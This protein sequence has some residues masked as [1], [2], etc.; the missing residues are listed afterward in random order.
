MTTTS[1]GPADPSLT[2]AVDPASGAT[3]P[4]I[5]TGYE[6]G[7]GDQFRAYVARVR[8]GEMGMLPAIGGLIVLTALFAFLYL[9][10]V[11]PVV[12]LVTH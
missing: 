8:G 3:P 10:V 11:A 6:G 5:A 12:L 9:V 2:T 4:G 7:I 1:K